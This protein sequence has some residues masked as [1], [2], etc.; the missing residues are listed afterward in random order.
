MIEGLLQICNKLPTLKESC[1]KAQWLIQSAKRDH[2]LQACNLSEN[3]KLTPV[4]HQT[5]SS[6]PV[7]NLF[8]D[9]VAN[10]CLRN[11]II[12]GK[13]FETTLRME[14]LWRLRARLKGLV[15]QNHK[16]AYKRERPHEAKRRGQTKEGKHAGRCSVFFILKINKE[17]CLNLSP[18]FR[19]KRMEREKRIQNRRQRDRRIVDFPVQICTRRSARRIGERRES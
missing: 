19:D 1:L 2:L 10:F 13:G 9:L 11:Y 12:L 16:F 17:Y 18:T 14:L 8:S 15:R 6:R 5:T 4:N 7:N 3:C